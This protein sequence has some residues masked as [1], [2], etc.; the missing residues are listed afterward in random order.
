MA[1]MLALFVAVANDVLVH[2]VV[3]GFGP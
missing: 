3:R 2:W 1:I